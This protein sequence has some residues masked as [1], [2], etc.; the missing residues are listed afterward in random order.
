VSTL[1]S[2]GVIRTIV[3]E[4]FALRRELRD[5]QPVVRGLADG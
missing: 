4:M 2:L 3:T 5:L 1:S